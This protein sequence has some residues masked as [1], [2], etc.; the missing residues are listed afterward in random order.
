MKNQKSKPYGMKDGGRVHVNPNML[1]IG[2]ARDAGVALGGRQR[3][4]DTAIDQDVTPIITSQV[5]IGGGLSARRDGAVPPADML[6][7]QRRGMK[8][9]GSPKEDPLSEAMRLHE[10]HM[11]GAIKPTAASQEK[12]MS[13]LKIHKSS[14]GMKDGGKVKYKTDGGK[15]TGPGGPTDDKAGTYDLSNKEYVLPADTTAAVG[16][17]N[18]DALRNATHKFVDEKNRGMANGGSEEEKRR[19]RAGGSE[20]K[21]SI[22]PQSV[23]EGIG[24]VGGVVARRIGGALTLANNLPGNIAAPIAT[25]AS[26]FGANVRTGYTGQ[27]QTGTEYVGKPLFGDPV[28]SAVAAPVVP[29]NTIA[30]PVTAK[31]VSPAAPAQNVATPQPASVALPPVSAQ[32]QPNY[33]IGTFS[34][35]S[36]R[37]D[38]KQN[39]FSGSGG[40]GSN[41]VSDQEFS[42]ATARAAGDRAKLNALAVSGVNEGT[43]EGI[44][45]AYRLAAGDP[46]ATAAVEAAIKQNKLS[47]AALGGN[48]NA[49]GILNQ[50][51]E[52]ENRLDI[53]N[54]GAQSDQARLGIARGA[55]DIQQKQFESSDAVNKIGIKT[56]Q[57]K[58]KDLEQAT[59]L[60]DQILAM[61]D[62]D[63]KRAGLVKKYNLLSGKDDGLSQKDL[64]DAFVQDSKARATNGEPP[65]DFQAFSRNITGQ[66]GSGVSREAASDAV[67]RGADKATVNKRL[68]AAGL[69]PI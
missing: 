31:P 65:Q 40:A 64:L 33:G 26:G 34:A 48:K 27:P 21:Q 35:D 5:N 41:S 12:L 49:A 28:Q 9:G 44:D 53:A 69:Q 22:R 54:I 11:S 62:N 43:T 8:D 18:L 14:M 32:P 38:G 60:R 10:S 37:R 63:P 61:P 16:I 3:Q 29:T 39:V 4:L 7:R 59:A 30:R 66:G 13:L 17:G 56:S 52:N 50:Q 51:S 55:Q 20:I 1:G 45:R 57:A 46:E 6:A 58:L 23:G 25:A 19:R 68:V 67:K 2:L 47:S 24:A 15:I 36:N 42:A